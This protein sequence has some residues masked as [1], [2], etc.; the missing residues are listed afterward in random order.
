[1]IR[2]PPRSTLF[3]YTTLFRSRSLDRQGVAQL[4][5]PTEQG[6]LLGEGV[7]PRVG[8]AEQLER[9]DVLHDAGLLIV[10]LLHQEAVVRD[11]GWS[12]RLLSARV[13]RRGRQQ[14]AAPS[15]RPPPHEPISWHNK[16]CASSRPTTR[17]SPEGTSA[18]V[19]G[20]LNGWRSLTVSSTPGVSPC[21]AK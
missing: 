13:G 16:S 8:A 18:M 9:A 10:G 7:G 11:G 21:S 15:R 14:D 12:R 17:G 2:R 19:V 4:V 6:P 3:P 5:G 1:M 20:P